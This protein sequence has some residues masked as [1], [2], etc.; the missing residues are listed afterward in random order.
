MKIARQ[1]I[2]YTNFIFSFLRSF[3]SKKVQKAKTKINTF[4]LLR[5]GVRPIF[6][7]RARSGIF[8][9]VKYGLD[10]SN[11]RKVCLMSPLTI[12]DLVNMVSSA[13]AKPEFYDFLPSSFSLD[14]KSIER[15]FKKGDIS[16]MIITHYHLIDDSIFD[17]KRICKA[18]KVLL[19][20]DCAISIGSQLKGRESGSFG[21][22]AIFSFSLFKFINFFWGGVVIANSKSAHQYIV[23]I[24]NKWE[25]LSFLDYQDQLFK[26]FKYGFFTINFV[27]ELFFHI[28]RWGLKHNIS[29][30]K[31]NM[32][33][34]PFVPLNQ[35][36]DKTY[37]SAPHDAFYI[38]LASKIGIFYQELEKRRIK[39]HYLFVALEPYGVNFMTQDIKIKDASM[40]NYPLIFNSEL[41]RNNVVMHL[42][43]FGVDTSTQIYRNIHSINGYK[44]IKGESSNI[45]AMIK[46][47]IFLPIHRAVS[48]DST[49]KIALILRK[50]LDN[51]D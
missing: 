1:K 24:T 31:K 27:Y 29:F 50:F 14:L 25:P 17:L 36:M 23:S 2:Y 44:G 28:F 16:S 8:L 39:A 51:N 38:E 32:Q 49:I 5:Y 41:E 15:R 10:K 18:H 7:G 4:F 48:L 22:I 46:R 9:A 13:G 6:I 12:M 45:N 30:I 43:D 37:F 47:M 20:E 33:N 3:F 26:Y 42:L 40:I 35:A 19:I 11:K 21:D 34:D